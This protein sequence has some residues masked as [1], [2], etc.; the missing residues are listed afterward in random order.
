MRVQSYLFLDGRC[1]EALGLYRRALDAEVTMMMRNRESPDPHPPGMLPPGSEDKIMHAEF[2]VGDTVIMAS[3]GLCSGKAQF[4]G[5]SLA[6]TVADD[7]TAKQRF[8]ALA[9]GGAVQ[10]P[11]G[12]TFFATS[13]GM[14]Q[15]R[16]G[17]GWMVLAPK[18]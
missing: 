1:E 12:P 17:I 6:I 11:L 15:D 4:T 7:A 18:A 14:V 8:D 16:F 10:M 13:F 3:D 5:F 9:E 2:R